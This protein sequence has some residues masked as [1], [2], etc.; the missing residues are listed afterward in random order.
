MV[1][2]FGF[3]FVYP[4]TTILLSDFPS[5]LLQNVFI[6]I[7]MRLHHCSWLVYLLNKNPRN[8]ASTVTMAM[9]MIRN[10]TPTMTP[11][12]ALSEGGDVD[13]DIADI[14]ATQVKNITLLL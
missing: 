10:I 12:G 5:C 1:T 3:G 9:L 7:I 14:E 2:I 13:V 6:P 4:T 8:I 11:T